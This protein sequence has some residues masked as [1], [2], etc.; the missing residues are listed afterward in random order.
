MHVI[1]Y[2][3]TICVWCLVLSSCANMV[4]SFK[5]IYVY[6]ICPHMGIPNTIP[7]PVL[8]P[9]HIGMGPDICRYWYDEKTNIIPVCGT[10]ALC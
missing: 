10:I 8:Y 6:F 9:H 1:N 3:V 7:T 2:M 4:F 5:Y